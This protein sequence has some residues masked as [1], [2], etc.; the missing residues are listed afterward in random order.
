MRQ[1]H[2]QNRRLMKP[3]GRHAGPTTLSS[4][5]SGESRDLWKYNKEISNG[6]LGGDAES[7]I[8]AHVAMAA[9]RMPDHVPANTFRDG[10]FPHTYTTMSYQEYPEASSQPLL[11][12]LSPLE[13]ASLGL[14]SHM[15]PPRLQEDHKQELMRRADPTTYSAGID[16]A[17][18]GR[19]KWRTSDAIPM[20]QRRQAPFQSM[21]AT[22]T[23]LPMFGAA[24]VNKAQ[25]RGVLLGGGSAILNQQSDIERNRHMERQSRPIVDDQGRSSARQVGGPGT[26]G[27]VLSEQERMQV[28]AQIRDFSKKMMDS[29]KL[30]AQHYKLMLD[31]LDKAR[32]YE[33]YMDWILTS[34]AWLGFPQALLLQKVGTAIK[35]GA[36]T[37]IE[38]MGGEEPLSVTQ[39][40]A[41]ILGN[42]FYG[43]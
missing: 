24:A 18:T 17:V 3:Y 41:Q 16:T 12:Q 8:S 25:N 33:N 10:A 13:F 14:M 9:A 31:A 26:G 30:T 15:F 7:S 29:G 42:I 39:A 2:R 36:E 35:T 19:Y 34:A 23:N 37:V 43:Q 28:N 5:Q 22:S 6:G 1:Q 11:Q 21:T 32:T 27:V 20:Q 4:H 40:I 38:G